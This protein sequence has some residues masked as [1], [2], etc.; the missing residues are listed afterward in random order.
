VLGKGQDRQPLPRTDRVGGV[1]S[2]A[3]LRAY[4]N[5]WYYQYEANVCSHEELTANDAV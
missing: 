3:S 5:M 4:Q 2:V 1:I